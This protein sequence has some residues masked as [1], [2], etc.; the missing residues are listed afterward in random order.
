MP[1][2][3]VIPGVRHS[4][5]E[6]STLVTSTSYARVIALLW[7]FKGTFRGISIGYEFH[8]GK[9]NADSAYGNEKTAKAVIESI[10]QPWLCSGSVV[11]TPSEPAGRR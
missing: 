9:A 5:T 10:E 3:N 6:A 7:Q 4:L 2:S 11:S 8:I 1:F